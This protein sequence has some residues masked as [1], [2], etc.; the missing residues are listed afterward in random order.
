MNLDP[1]LWRE[2]RAV[3]GW[4]ALTVALGWAAGAAM[5]LWARGLSRVISRVF[6]DGR[7]LHEVGSLLFVLLGIALAR[8]AFTWAG[9]VAAH[10]V[11]GQVKRDVRE[12]FL[13]RV[14]ALGPAYAR[15]ERTG[16]L[17]N[18]AVEG[19]ESLDAYFSQYLPQV[20][21]TALVPLTFLLLV[22]PLDALSGVVLLLT[23]PII[24][25]FMILIGSLADALS[26]RQW[27][28]LSRMSAHFL[29]ALQGLT[30]LKLFGR[31]KEQVQVIAQISDQFRRTT[32]GVLRVAFLS[33]LVQEL[34]A[35]LSTAIVAV[36]IGLRLLYGR[37]SFEQALFVL[38]LAP[39]FYLPLRQLGVRFH[40]SVSGVTAAR[41]IFEVLGEA[42]DGGRQTTDSRPRITDAGRRTAVG[43][44]PS[45]V[46][47]ENVSYSYANAAQEQEARSAL[48]GV[49]F[50]IEPGQRVALVGP[51]GAGKSTVAQ[52]L[53]R[54]IE[55]D[56]G[57]ITVNGL[58]LHDIPAEAWRRQVA[59]VSQNP[60]LFNTTV[61]ENIRLA[62]PEA[63]TQ[64]II[65]AAQEAHA[66]E[67][68]QAL[69]QG[70][71]TVIGERGA[72]LSGGQAQ[73][74]ALARAF[75]RDAPLLI[76]D[77][78]TSNLDPETE[79]W[80]RAS[81]ERLMRERMTLVIAHRLNTVYRADQIVVLEGGRVVETGTHTSLLETRGLYW[82]L[83]K[84]G[85]ET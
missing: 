66:H 6:L 3:R 70:Y 32:L 51:S 79:D 40:A 17:T 78:A 43:C 67:F 82:R 42:T 30:T 31:A 41:R 4:L 15:G 20:A 71:D 53:L 57:L 56:G 9:E 19:V 14:M 48:K 36:E 49:S 12:R 2:A 5:A 46:R 69:P 62:R 13:S 74:I 65:R 72:R 76:L 47:F 10:R 16:E 24:P 68:I 44:V 28:S 11:A 26:R 29:D 25:V 83:V 50:A 52:L 21:L 60:Y 38:I 58:P 80:I 85:R 64:A 22:F 59:W 81:T 39:E 45:A 34:V 77:E 7:S 18:T 61:A 35:T 8:A 63:G 23:A 55:P 33:A 73:R 54:F 27:Q 84:A 37:L 75:L 1:R